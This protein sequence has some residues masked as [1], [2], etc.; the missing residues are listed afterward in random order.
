[1]SRRWQRFCVVGIG[2]HARTKLIPAILAN[3][4][5]LAGLVSR[6]AAADLP[7]APLFATP[8]EALGGLP[9]DTVFVIASPPTSHFGQAMTF[10]AAGRDVIVEKPPFVTAEEARTAVATAERAG[11]ILVEGF[12][13][14]YTATY[15][16]FLADW[17]AASPVAVECSFTIP[18]APAAT[19][20]VESRIGSSNLY[21]M[22]SYLLAALL[23]A[24]LSLEGLSLDGVDQAGEPDRERLHLSGQLGEIAVR[25]IVGVDTAY[26]NRLSLT[27]ADG[28]VLAYEPFFYGRAGPRRLSVAGQ[29]PTRERTIEDEDAF[30]SMF[31]IPPRAW[32]D[33][34]PT[35]HARMISLTEQL[36]R[37]GAELGRFRRART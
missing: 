32:R 17:A 21:D 5:T 31:A 10:L 29:G 24:G 19:F 25:A 20:R 15:E 11:A 16:T 27:R 34:Q 26:V 13:N 3:G 1:M 8:E 33:A 7:E 36:E 12:M 18:A 14:R 4:Q 28:T 35:H 9:A 23:D 30:R 22:A 2:G 6:K 37:L